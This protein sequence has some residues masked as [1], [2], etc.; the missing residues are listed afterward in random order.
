MEQ[1][2]TRLTDI[3][4]EHRLNTAG[5]DAVSVRLLRS[6]TWLKGYIWKDHPVDERTI[7]T[8]HFPL[9]LPEVCK[10]LSS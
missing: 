9:L 2:A 3:D 6:V 10:R 5:H 4:T 1:I 7:S 8:I